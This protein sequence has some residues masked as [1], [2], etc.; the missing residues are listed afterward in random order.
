MEVAFI[1]LNES[2]FEFLVL[3]VVDDNVNK[4][5]RKMFEF[6]VQHPQTIK[7]LKPDAVLITSIRYKD[8]IMR[9]LNNNRELAGINFYSL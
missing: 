7:E 6:Q 9:N 1:I 5:G 8:K 4:H 3:A 2:N